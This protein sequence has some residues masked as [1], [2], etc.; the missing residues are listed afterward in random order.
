M[1]TVHEKDVFIALYS[2]WS[3]VYLKQYSPHCSD[4]V[5]HFYIISSPCEL[6]NEVWICHSTAC[7][8]VCVSVC[9]CVGVNDVT[10]RA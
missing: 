6:P 1:S 7:V 4:L 8:F 3:V 9:V 2:C 10:T 5:V